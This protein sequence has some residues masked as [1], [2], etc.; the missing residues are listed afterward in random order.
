[1]V[2]TSPIPLL[3]SILNPENITDKVSDTINWSRYRDDGFTI[4]PNESDIDELEKHLQSLCPGKIRWTLSHGKEVEYLDVRVNITKDGKLRTDVFSKNSH[5]YLPPQSCHPPSVFKGLALSI[6]RRLRM[7]CSDDRDLDGRIKEYTKY[8][9]TS[10]WSWRKA[11]RDLKKGAS[12]PR[13]E[14]LKE[15]KKKSNRTK[16]KIAWVTTYDPRVPSK[17]RIIKDNLVILHS[18]PENKEIFPTKSLIAADKRRKNIGEI[19][20]PTVPRR[21]VPHGPRP[22]CGFFLCSKKC[23]TCKH[24]VETHQFTSPW[25]GRKWQIRDFITCTTPNVIYIVKCLSHP[26]FLY[27]GSTN[28]LKKRWANHKSDCKKEKSNKC[29]VSNHVTSQPHTCS[30]DIS[31]LKIIAIEVVRSEYRLLERE[32]FWQAN[33]GTFFTG[34]NVRKDFHKVSKYRVHHNIESV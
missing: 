14:T 28:N 27:V 5:S 6:G 23:D 11:N 22:E 33:L 20:K 4:I 1:M 16:K 9:V 25:D 32:I 8:L 31:F 34:G 13:C 29:W 7:I 2:D 18:N 12:I 3:T 26:D 21:F 10:G 17:S 15:K 30:N 19:Y 24:S